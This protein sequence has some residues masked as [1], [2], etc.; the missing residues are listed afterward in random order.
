MDWAL[1]GYKKNDNFGAF[2]GE[3]KTKEGLK[4]LEEKAKMQG[5]IKFQYSHFDGSKPDF[6]KTIN[7]E[8]KGE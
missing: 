1:F 6:T 7:T 2:L 3:S 5:Y 8:T 4:I